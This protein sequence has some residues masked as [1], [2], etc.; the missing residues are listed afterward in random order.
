M[1]RITFGG[2][3]CQEIPRLVLPESF[4][5]YRI[6]ETETLAACRR[7]IIF[8]L[9]SI[10]ILPRISR[11]WASELREQTEVMRISWSQRVESLSFFF[12]RLE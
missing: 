7:T 8:P 1:T 11:D 6:N 9:T 2:A 5:L 10:I 12:P 3:V 4:S